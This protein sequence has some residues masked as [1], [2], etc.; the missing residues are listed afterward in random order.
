MSNEF[1]MANCECVRMVADPRIGHLVAL[2]CMSLFAYLMAHT[3]GL[4]CVIVVSPQV[5]ILSS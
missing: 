5:R 1:W 2:A 4:K 3:S